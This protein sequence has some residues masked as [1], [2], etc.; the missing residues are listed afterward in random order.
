MTKEQFLEGKEFK[1]FEGSDY[2][3][4]LSVNNC[5]MIKHKTDIC[6]TY[7]AYIIIINDDD[8]VAVTN[9]MGKNQYSNFYFNDLILV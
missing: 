7:H 5:I 4:K 6:F 3:Y 1:T 8:F 9:L 2:T